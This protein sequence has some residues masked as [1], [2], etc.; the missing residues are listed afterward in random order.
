MKIFLVV[1]EERGDKEDIEKALQD[2]FGYTPEVK[3]LG[4][5]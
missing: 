4:N 2:Y 3:E 1:I 5:K